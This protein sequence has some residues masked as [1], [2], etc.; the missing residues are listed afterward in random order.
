MP[1][2]IIGLITGTALLLGSFTTVSLTGEPIAPGAA[3]SSA[4]SQTEPH[5]KEVGEAVERFKRG[6]MEG[7][8]SILETA[9]K[10]YPD[11]PPA[12]VVLAQLFSQTKQSSV[13]RGL[14]EMAVRQNPQD[15]EA[16]QIL[17][18]LALHERR[19][20]EASLLYERAAALL[21]K[22]DRSP[23]R[24]S[25]LQPRVCS[26]QAAVAEVYEDWAGAQKH[27]EAWLKLEPKSTA[28]MQ[29]LA[30]ALFQQRKA[31]DA[32]K[33]LR[34]A[35]Q[36]DPEVLTPEA[37]LAGFYERFGDHANAK[38]WMTYALQKAPS[39]PKTRLVAANWALE[40]NQYDVAQEH[41]AKAMQLDPKSRD[42]KMLRGVISLFQKDFKN[43][44]VYFEAAHLHSP[45]YFPATN[46]LALALVEQPD[47]T[48][49]RRAMEYAQSNARQHPRVA[50]A[51][52]TY[53]WVLY[54]T[55]QTDQAEQ[56]LTR[57]ASMGN[58]TSDTA[59]YLARVYADKLRKDEAKQLLQS[60]LKN[61]GLFSQRQEA[62]ALLNELGK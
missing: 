14:L 16:Y 32:L 34:Y 37:M 31:D 20:T 25:L 56:V 62:Q 46:N 24:K 55:G 19:V 47:E 4:P 57:A 15:P 50:E 38:K 27:L 33:L 12:Q 7:A 44:E 60:A 52:S 41:A 29:R 5:V 9:A 40:T 48:K 3:V 13:V 10:K 35:A 8:Q 18:E 30:W 61:P 6:D 39:D 17:G 59:Y 21:A 53:G 1:R 22:F 58:M 26:G 23:K 28:A 36:I 54:R 43:A 11:L 2:P 45:G 42:A 51:A 49:K